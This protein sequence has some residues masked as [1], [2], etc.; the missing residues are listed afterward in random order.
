[1][2]VSRSHFLLLHVSVQC[3]RG[4][5]RWPAP[6]TSIASNRC[7]VADHNHRFQNVN[8]RLWTVADQHEVAVAAHRPPFSSLP[9]PFSSISLMATP[10]E[11]RPQTTTMDSW[12]PPTVPTAKQPPTS[13]IFLLFP[14]CPPFYLL[15]SL[16]LSLLFLLAL[17]TY[18]WT[19]INHSHL[20]SLHADVNVVSK[21]ISLIHGRDY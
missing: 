9:L 11:R 15:F 12:R 6:S 1:L 20:L 17:D 21:I 8:S 7:E 18:T 16:F 3:P 10:T 19:N 4:R 2:R 5:H 13:P 14:I